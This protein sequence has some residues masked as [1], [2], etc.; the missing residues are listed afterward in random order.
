MPVYYPNS[1]LTLK[2]GKPQG[3]ILINYGVTNQSGLMT[4]L[5]LYRQTEDKSNESMAGH[6]KTI[7]NVSTELNS[8][9]NTVYNHLIVKIE[10]F[11]S[12]YVKKYFN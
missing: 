5:L 1:A 9:I 11:H 7:A 10:N 2:C 6:F 8:A 4:Y 12:T 3:R